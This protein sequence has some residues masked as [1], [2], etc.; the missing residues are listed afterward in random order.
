MGTWARNTSTNAFTLSGSGATVALRSTTQTGRF[1]NV[2]DLNTTAHEV[3][4]VLFATK[5]RLNRI[6]VGVVGANVVMRKVA[7]GGAAVVLTN[8][9]SDLPASASCSVAHGLTAGVPYQVDARVVDGTIELWI[10]ETKVLSHQ[11]L[12]TETYYGNVRIGAQKYVGFVSSVSGAVVQRAQICSLVPG[13]ITP[14]TEVDVIVVDGN[15]F[16][17]RD[18]ETIE[19]IASKAFNPTGPV[20]LAAKRAVVYGVD[21]TNA[22]KID[23]SAKTVT[24]WGGTT[25]STALPGAT[26]TAPSSG[27]FVA[28]TTRMTF[29]FEFLSRLGL[30]GDDQDPQNLFFCAVDDPDDWNTGS[31]DYG[32]AFALSA[33]GPGRVGEP[34]KCAFQMSNGVLGIGCLNS[35]WCMRG[36]PIEAIPRVTPVLLNDGI[37]GK[38]SMCLAREGVVAAFGPNGLYVASADGDAQN[39]S[40]GQLTE[41]LNLLASE[42]GDYR[43][44]VTRDPVANTLHVFR[45]REDGVQSSHIAYDERI[46]Q[47]QAPSFDSR[48]NLMASG[49]FFTD[50]YPTTLEPT[51][52]WISRGRLVMGTR[53][54]KITTF[55]HDVTT[56]DGTAVA[57]RY[58]VDLLD[59]GDLN[60]DTVLSDLALVPSSGSAAVNIR[61]YG[62]RTPEEAFVG[63]NRRLLRAREGYTYADAG[64]RMVWR[65]R[66][67][68]LVLEVSSDSGSIA[69]ERMEVMTYPARRLNRH[70]RTPITAPDAPCEFPA[71]SSG[72]STGGDDG[73]GAGSVPPPSDEWLVVLTQSA[74]DSQDPDPYTT[75]Y[76]A[77]Q[78]GLTMQT[79][80]SGS[81]Q[82]DSGSGVEIDEF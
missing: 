61:V 75:V 9:A 79:D 52:A 16:M 22:R 74:I 3:K 50:Q 20:S 71:I 34:V 69:V 44:I 72:S 35:F 47:Y 7:L 2:L 43:V 81:T 13:E 59:D 82:G 37:W 42:R 15:V 55:S 12:D 48:G 68:A 67:P 70:L 40:A 14:Q 25:L 64:S 1:A 58:A 28:G 73:P 18:G 46:G 65:V 30:G 11:L 4:A 29:A 45:T 62:G 76:L 32:R 57:S 51:C 27:V 54:S 33:G 26:E 31:L 19:Q 66:A 38:D 17:S 8:S 77:Q 56:D 80:Q 60:N 49:G 21:G 63:T 53:G 5:D 41:G 6:E 24:N 36:D 10:N 39:F 78:G 23:P